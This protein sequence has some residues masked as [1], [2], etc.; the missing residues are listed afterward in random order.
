MAA[1]G[2]KG[3]RKYAA[4]AEGWK[5]VKE[6]KLTSDTK[7]QRY[8]SGNRAAMCAKYEKNN[9]KKKVHVT[10]QELIIRNMKRIHMHDVK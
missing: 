9:N 8:P 2:R 6:K 1:V 10:S 7:I 5:R 4:P 3:K